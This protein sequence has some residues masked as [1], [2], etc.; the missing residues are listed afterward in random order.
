MYMH[1]HNNNTCLLYSYENQVIDTFQKIYKA[2]DLN[3]PPGSSFLEVLYQRL[4]AREQ[5][6]YIGQLELSTYGFHNEIHRSANAESAFWG[7]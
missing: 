7:I 3:P 5:W 2:N 6:L 1:I 4:C